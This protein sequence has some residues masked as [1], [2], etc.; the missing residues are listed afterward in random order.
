[1]TPEE[2]RSRIRARIE[3][4]E[5][6]RKNDTLRIASD[7]KALIQLRIQT[8]GTDAKGQKFSPYTAKYAKYGRR[9]QGYQDRYFDF[10]RTGRAFANIRPTVIDETDNS[11]TVEVAGQN[12]LT[13]QKLAGQ[14]DKRGNILTPSQTE[15]D[16]ANESNRQRILKYLL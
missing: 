11:V 8:D 15:I 7:L 3:E 4:L 14:F 10:T 2:F 6:N 16:I 5:A 13:K 12:T 9:E 1:M